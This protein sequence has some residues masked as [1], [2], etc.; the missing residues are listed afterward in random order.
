MPKS[1]DLVKGYTE[2]LQ[3]MGLEIVD[4]IEELLPKVDAVLLESLD[5]R[6]HLQQARP[7]IEAGKPIFIDKPL[8]ASLADAVEIFRLAKEHGVPCFSSSLAALQFR[9]H[10]HA[11][12]SRRGR[13]DRLFGLQPQ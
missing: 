9:D 3:G 11:Q 7:V 10:R 5:G 6:P 8:A 12:R 2:K 13:S 4:S 1:W